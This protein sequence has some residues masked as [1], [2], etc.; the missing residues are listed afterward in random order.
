MLYQTFQGASPPLTPSGHHHMSSNLMPGLPGLIPAVPTTA[1]SSTPTQSSSHHLHFNTT[2]STTTHVN[3][4]SLMSLPHS[5]VPSE[6]LQI[7]HGALVHP[8]GPLHP[9]RTN[10]GVS[11]SPS[12]SSSSSSSSTSEPSTIHRI[13]SATHA[14]R[15]CM[16]TDRMPNKDRADK[17]LRDV[18]AQ[19]KQTQGI[20]AAHGPHSGREADPEWQHKK[21]T[22]N[23]HERVYESFKRDFG[24]DEDAFFAFFTVPDTELPAN[25]KRKRTTTE[26]K[27]RPFRYVYKALG[28]MTKDIEREM[29]DPQYKDPHTS[30]FSESAWQARW[31]TKNN[32]EVWRALGK[33]VYL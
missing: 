7:Q 6:Q 16:A 24:G 2:A 22:I 28:L 4:M 13:P 33:E 8:A 32:W 1:Y 18:I 23:R 30:R 27:L 31:G 19:F 12:P 20:R 26:P 9:T 14:L 15:T 29:Q 10:I 5:G 25:G 17:G 3:S 11:E 21:T